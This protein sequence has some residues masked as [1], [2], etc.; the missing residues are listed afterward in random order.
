M[1]GKIFYNS[2]EIKNFQGESDMRNIDTDSFIGA[3][4]IW[5]KNRRL[6]VNYQAGFRCDFKADASKKYTLKLTGASFYKVYLN[7][8]F[9]AYGPARAGMG[10]VRTDELILNVNCGINK[11]AVEAAG[12]NCASYYS[13]P[14][15]SFLT[16]EI[17]ED[18]KAFKYTGRDFK[19]VALDGLRSIQS[20]RYSLQR[21]FAE[22]WSFDNSKELTGWKTSDSIAY[23]DVFSFDITEKYLPRGVDYPKYNI[24]SYEK[25]DEKGAL[26][27]KDLTADSETFSRLTEYAKYLTDA[28]CLIDGYRWEELAQNPILELY[29]DFIPGEFTGTGNV[30]LSEDEYVIYK[31]PCNNTGFLRNEI[32]VSE[33]ATVFV[34]FAEYNSGNGMVFKSL[35]G[36]TNIVTYNLKASDT[37]YRLESFE[38]YTCQYIGVAVTKGKAEVCPPEIREYSY[39]KYENVKFESEDEELNAVFKAASNSFRQNTVDIY[40]DCP[41]RERGGWLCDT[42]FMSKSER[43]LAGESRVEKVFLENYTMAEEFPYMPQGMIPM[44]YPGCSRKGTFIPQW[45]IWYVLELYEYVN[46]RAEADLSEYRELVYGLLGWFE[47]YENEDGLLEKMPGWNFIEW[48]KANEWVQDVNYPTNMLYSKMLEYAGELFGD[49]S[50]SD[51]GKRVMAAVIS[52]SFDG[53]YFH[54]HS[55]RN[56]KGELELCGDISETCQYYAYFTGAADSSEKFAELTDIVVNVFGPENRDC[57]SRKNIAPANAFIGNYLRL[58]ILLRM[59]RFDMA[60]S[61]IRGYFSDMARITGTLWEHNDIARGSLNHGFTSYAAVA[62]CFGLSGISDINYKEKTIF[63]DESYTSGK[64]FSFELNTEDGAICITEKKGVKS[65]DIPTGWT[66]SGI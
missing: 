47:R 41:G 18:G 24:Q 48:S 2:L 36:T 54:D 9:I 28:S 8:E 33:D 58:I 46:M 62:I 60:V 34:F 53:K 20:H 10:Y 43:F 63:M 56:E 45:S 23:A 22:V 35:G 59:K 42:Y 26:K 3:K 15:R 16:A 25:L 55:K 29:G 65:I 37:S 39:P 5:I 27:H 6:T 64:D 38:P 21:T 61:D 44:V 66:V 4:P 32:K 31:M 11:L 12:Y 40:M 14:I 30:S 52:Q 17:Y 13:M 57:E 51:K 19:G 50:L 7:G 49:S 1:H